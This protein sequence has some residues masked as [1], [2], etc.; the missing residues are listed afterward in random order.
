VLHHIPGEEQRVELLRQARDL[1]KPG[2]IFIHSEWQFQFSARLMARRMPWEFIG[3]S[4]EDVEPGDTLMDWRYALPGQAE[5]VG[6]RYVHLFTRGEL[7]ELAE[8]AGFEIEEEFES[9]GEGGRLGVYQ[10]WVKIDR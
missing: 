7:A 5:Q 6:Y 4:N 9:D 3:L 1:I 2:G 8:R 10:R